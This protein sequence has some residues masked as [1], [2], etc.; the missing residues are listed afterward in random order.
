MQPKK[1]FPFIAFRLVCSLLAISAT[2]P[3]YAA[4]DSAF[5]RSTIVGI[6]GWLLLIIVFTVGV[7]VL[8]MLVGH[9]GF[10]ANRI[11]AER[12]CY[13]LGAILVVKAAS[14]QRL[15]ATASTIL[16]LTASVLTYY[17]LSRFKPNS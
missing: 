8:L 15:P 16:A 2:V 10:K 17:L 5:G 4:S 14:A 13:S 12:I 1:G 9:Y 3:A 11:I 6:V 7:L